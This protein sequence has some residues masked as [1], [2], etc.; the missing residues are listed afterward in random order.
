MNRMKITQR[1][2]HILSAYTFVLPGLLLYLLFVIYP[3]LK[4]L[5]MSFFK[6]SIVPGIP[7]FDS[8]MA[9]LSR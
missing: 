9:S 1:K 6:W 2:Q 8:S 4:A 3:I 5:Q 7:S